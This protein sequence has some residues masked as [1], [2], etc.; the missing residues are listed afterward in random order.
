MTG[1]LKL[2]AR[3][4]RRQGRSGALLLL[5]IG[6]A[7]ATAALSAVSVFT[8]RVGRA[9]ER[10]AGE[11]LAADLVVSGRDR[12]PSEFRAQARTMGLE[13]AELILLSTVLFAGDQSQLIDVKGVDGDYPMRGTLR[14]SPA[15][16]P[17]ARSRRAARAGWNRAACGCSTPNR[18]LWL[19]WAVYRSN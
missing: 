4:L 2:S 13:T 19:T 17:D 9:L 6:L 14:L 10:Q 16:D 15:L 3:L 18:A 8:D 11:S 7:V 5:L 12:L 1:S